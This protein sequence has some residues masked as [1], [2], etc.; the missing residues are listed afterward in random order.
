MTALLDVLLADDEGAALAEGFDRAFRKAG[1]RL[2][3]E[4][5]ADNV[6]ARVDKDRPAA[7]LLDVLFPR[8]GR[9]EPIG[10][11]LIR[12]LKNRYPALP[13]VLLTATMTDDRNAPDEETLG[14]ADFSFAKDALYGSDPQVALKQLIEEVHAAID[15]VA[16][17]ANLDERL[18]FYVGT[19]EVMQRLAEQAVRLAATEISVLITGE[20]GTGKEELARAIHRLSPKSAG[21]FTALNC[22]EFL[23][24]EL[25]QAE[26]FG[27]ERGAHSTAREAKAGVIVSTS[28]GTL[29]LDE[30]QAMTPATQQALLRTL[31]FKTVRPLGATEDRHVDVRIISATNAD[32]GKMVNSG[33]FRE[34]TFQRLVATRLHLPALRERKEDISALALRFI[35]QA[36]EEIKPSVPV[37]SVL[38]ES[39]RAR[40]M[41]YDWPGNIRELRNAVF[42][43][44]TLA[45]W[46][47]L[48]PSIFEHGGQQPIRE[49][50]QGPASTSINPLSS[51]DELTWTALME[52]RGTL[53]R[54]QLIEF[55]RE[56]AAATGAKP[57]GKDL[58]ERLGISYDNLRRVLSE[59]KISLRD[60]PNI[61]RNDE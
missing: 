12:V 6:V 54:K 8:G 50:K 17:P 43:A 13:V 41:A 20:P 40:L 59:A 4:T 35:E 52:M 46:N 21:P 56:V 53:R 37:L 1:L 49:E 51:K 36:N 9:F 2:S 47:V 48:T 24:E 31:Q 27:Y 25:L 15:R 5:S 44:V 60:W 16:Q 55:I 39:V 45:R 58:A 22:G 29:F 3:T 28:D 32:P 42:R 23:N 10:L 19:T 18:G 34:D 14:L 33:E 38:R 61:G 26:L 30:I 11:K 7:V 57:D